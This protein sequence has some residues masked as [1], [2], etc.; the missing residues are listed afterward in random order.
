[1]R[2]SRAARSASARRCAAAL[3][4][5]PPRVLDRGGDVDGERAGGLVLRVD[6]Q[7]LA[8]D[9]RRQLE[10]Q[11]RERLAAPR[12]FALDRFELSLP[13]QRLRPKVGSLGVGGIERRRL[14]ERLKSRGDVV[15]VQGGPRPT[16]RGAQGIEERA[17]LRL[18]ALPFEI[19]ELRLEILDRPADVAMRRPVGLELI[20]RRAMI[21]GLE[22]RARARDGLGGGGV[23]RL[24][25]AGGID[26]RDDEI[27]FL[28]RFGQIGRE[29]Q[30]RLDLRQRVGQSPGGARG[31]GAAQV[32]GD[33][34]AAGGFLFQS[35][36]PRV[37]FLEQRG[38]ARRCPAP[39]A[40][41][42]RARRSLP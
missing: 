18:L 10:I 31:C 32:V 22:S 3:L 16:Q 6:R 1:M 7:R 21:A 15:F 4:L 23:E 26:R 29:S 40:G 2:F 35:G 14:V 36:L 9:G 17:R 27:P 38:Q 33:L 34:T 30:R 20:D 42:A 11:V 12:D 39:P 28:Q 19:G 5:A 8:G 41:R 37:R 25:L 24:S 13:L